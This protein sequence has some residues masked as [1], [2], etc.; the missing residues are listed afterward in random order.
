MLGTGISFFVVSLGMGL[1]TCIFVHRC[2]VADGTVVRINPVQDTENDTVN[3]A[4]V[5]TFTATD[6]QAYTLTS[7][8]ASNPPGFVVGQQVKILYIKNDPSGARL[9]VCLM[10]IVDY[11][12][13]PLR[14]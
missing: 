5:F 13:W 9:V 12:G 3:Y 6:G 10:Q 2:V 1:Y 14:G 11:R 4:P 8:V 7:G